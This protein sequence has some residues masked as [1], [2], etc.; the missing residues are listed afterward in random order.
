VSRDLGAAH[1]CWR[2]P[3]INSRLLRGIAE[4]RAPNAS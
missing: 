3:V 1:G 4:N 2:S